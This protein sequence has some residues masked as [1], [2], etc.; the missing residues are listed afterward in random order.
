MPDQIRSKSEL[1]M[2]VS[3]LDADARQRVLDGALDDWQARRRDLLRERADIIRRQQA[4][5]ARLGYP[6]GYGLGQGLPG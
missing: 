2:M 1:A 4:L 6:T 5:A 3:D